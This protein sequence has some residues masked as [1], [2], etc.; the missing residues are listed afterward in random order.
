MTERGETGNAVSKFTEIDYV[1]DTYTQLP[2]P[3]ADGASWLVIEL[4]EFV[5]AMLTVRIVSVL[6]SKSKFVP[7]PSFIFVI[8]ASVASSL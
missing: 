1:E 7:F 2:S 8:S 4:H 6:T 5:V 3:L